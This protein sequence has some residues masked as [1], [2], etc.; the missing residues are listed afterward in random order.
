AG[1]FTEAD[2]GDENELFGRGGFLQRAQTLLHDAMVIPGAGAPL[3]LGFGKA[4]EKQA[5]DAERSGLFGFADGLIDGEVEDAGHRADFA[6][7]AFAGTKEKR[8]D[9]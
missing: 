3:V 6:A 5:A 2:V 4:E 9:E 7:D 8:I 1:V